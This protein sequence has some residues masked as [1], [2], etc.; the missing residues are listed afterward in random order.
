MKMANLARALEFGASIKTPPKT[1][2][3]AG[4]TG[5]LGPYPEGG[6]VGSLWV[7]LTLTWLHERSELTLEEAD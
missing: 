7:A 1:M 2:V 6:C 4:Y 5:T 3:G